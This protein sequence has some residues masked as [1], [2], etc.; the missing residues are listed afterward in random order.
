MHVLEYILY[1]SKYTFNSWYWEE[2]CQRNTDKSIN[3]CDT[4]KYV[5][6]VLGGAV[7]KI[8]RR[9]P[10]SRNHRQR[11]PMIR[12]IRLIGP[13]GGLMILV[14]KTSDQMQQ[15]EQTQFLF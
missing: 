6:D 1:V 7:S 3:Y 12:Q 2:P 14:T 15:R 4:P 13:K 8:Y 10:E 5:V 11:K 9:L